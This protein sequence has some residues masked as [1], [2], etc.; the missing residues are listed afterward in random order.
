MSLGAQTDPLHVI[1]TYDGVQKTIFFRAHN[2]ATGQ[3]VSNTYPLDL[4]TM[5]T[6]FHFGFSGATGHGRARELIDSWTLT[7][8]PRG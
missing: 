6:S 7:V 4:S 8:T 1:V 5:G 3:T 2:S